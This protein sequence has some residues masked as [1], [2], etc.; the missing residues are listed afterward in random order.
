MFSLF[1]GK[2][3]CKAFGVIPQEGGLAEPNHG[4]LDE[5]V[6]SPVFV[7]VGR[8]QRLSRGGGGGL[9]SGT[10]DVG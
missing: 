10:C 7:F 1:L 5:P 8:F 3:V 4:I 6:L 9:V 2:V